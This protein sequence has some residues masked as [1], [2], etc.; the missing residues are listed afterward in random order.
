[1]E[2]LF[3]GHINPYLFR[4]RWNGEVTQGKDSLKVFK[5][6]SKTMYYYRKI[7]KRHNLVTVQVSHNIYQGNV[8]TGV[9]LST[10]G[11][12]VGFPAC[13]TGHMARGRG[14]CIQGRGLHLVGWGGLHLGGWADPPNV[15]RKAGGTH[16]TGKL[17]CFSSNLKCQNGNR[18]YGKA[19][20]TYSKNGNHAFK[21]HSMLHWVLTI[22]YH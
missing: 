14:I 8:F 11:E 12:W 22:F 19:F 18:I 16:P 9:C 20:T 15:T 3:Y 4:S 1:M 6:S 10:R 7:L 21:F 13:I 17:S 2:I 5:A